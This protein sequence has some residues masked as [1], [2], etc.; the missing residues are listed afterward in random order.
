MEL[1]ELIK[2][3]RS[4]RRFYQDEKI[5]NQI[6]EDAINLARLSASAKNLQPLKY[7]VSNDEKT[8]S[9][10]FGALGFAGY[11][12]DWNGPKEGERPSAYIIIVADKNIPLTFVD[13]DLGI[14]MQSIMLGLVEQELGGCMIQ[15]I[16]KKKIVEI[17]DINET[18]Y[19]IMAVLAIGKPKENVILQDMKDNNYKYFRDAKQNHYVPKR[20]MEEILLN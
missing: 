13:V 17:L 20:T 2:K 12:K 1:K 9:E 15:S 4:Y 11:L 8:N 16:N 10:I 6:L 18:K 3:N 19:E 7:I 5:N 14:A